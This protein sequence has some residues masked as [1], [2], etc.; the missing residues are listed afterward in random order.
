MTK[1]SHTQR[2]PEKSISK[3][4]FLWLVEKVKGVHRWAF[5]YEGEDAYGEAMTVVFMLGNGMRIHS[6]WMSVIERNS[7]LWAILGMEKKSAARAARGKSQYLWQR[8]TCCMRFPLWSTS[9]NGTE[10][11]KYQNQ[12]K[13]HD[14]V[15]IHSVI[16]T[17]IQ[18]ICHIRSRTSD[19]RRISEAFPPI[20]YL[21]TT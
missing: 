18:D 15:R 16:S 1:L 4:T 9:L 5:G 21:V 7:D 14:N 19:F 6:F 10:Y 13:V 11:W 8:Q 17:R 3:T 2:L 12:G 20:F